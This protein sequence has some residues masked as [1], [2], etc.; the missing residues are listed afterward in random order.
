MQLTLNLEAENDHLRKLPIEE[1]PASLSAYGAPRRLANPARRTAALPRGTQARF[2]EAAGISADL[3]FPLNT[4]LTIRWDSLFSDND[5]NPL[6]YLPVPNRIDRL[7]ELLRKWLEWRD[8]PPA[9]IW[10]RE[11]TGSEG[12]HWHIAF[13]LP[14]ALHPQI[15]A[16]VAKQTGEPVSLR[17]RAHQKTPGEFACS[18]IRSWHLAHDLHPE[19]HGLYLAAYLGKA[20]PSQ[21][22]FRGKMVGNKKKPIRGVQFGGT[23]S[24]DKYD[25]PQGFILGTACRGDRFFI[26]KFLQQASKA[27]R[28]K[29]VKPKNLQ[30][31][32]GAS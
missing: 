3:G 23:E 20:E 1:A 2:I 17:H 15:I 6:R 11:A 4:L 28:V 8:L 32:S 19:R 13:H 9:Y 31:S 22:L 29:K 10:V 21:I 16:F 7:V 26:A 30:S 27:K 18:E 25:A 12:E 5:V 24:D 14:P